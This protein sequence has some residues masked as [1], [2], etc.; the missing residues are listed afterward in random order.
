MLTPQDIHEKEF[1]RN[2]K[3]YN[4]DEVD[5]FLDQI[6]QDYDKLIRENRELVARIDALNE[7]IESYRGMENTLMHTMVTAHKA[8][9]DITLSA[10]KEAEELRAKTQAECNNI[11]ERAKREAAQ[12]LNDRKQELIESEKKIMMLKELFDEFK[13]GVIAYA[14]EL[15]DFIDNIT[16]P[17]KT[18]DIKQDLEQN[19]KQ[20]EA[21]APEQEAEPEAAAEPEEEPQPEPEAAAQEEAQFPYEDYGRR[22]RPYY[23][24]PEDDIIQKKPKRKRR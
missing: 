7:Q 5:M 24:L 20:L 6:I 12:L 10:T 14:K 11:L 15:V 1:S 3:G 9:E 2:L 4:M 21:E 17:V 8:A 18:D 16:D 23:D 13:E 22:Q 19:M